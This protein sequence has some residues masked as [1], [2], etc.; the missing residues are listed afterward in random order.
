MDSNS[1]AAHEE[2]LQ[3]ALRVIRILEDLGAKA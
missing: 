2:P 1:G 3:L